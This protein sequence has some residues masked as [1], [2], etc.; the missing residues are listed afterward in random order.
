MEK[1]RI[2]RFLAHAGMGSRRK[3]EEFI[4]KGF[5]RVNGNVVKDLSKVVDPNVDVIEFK[6]KRVA[7]KRYYYLVLNK[8]KGYLTTVSDNYGR[9]H[10]MQL[11]PEQYKKAGVVPVGRLDKDTE[12]LLL[13]TNDGDVAYILTH[14]KFGVSKEYIVELDKPL[15]DRDKKK[16][17]GG[18]C[19]EKLRTNPAEIR[20]LDQ[21]NRRLI[22]K[23]TEGKKR[24]IR[25]TFGLFSY[26]IKKLKRI[27][28]GPLKLGNLHS[29]S[30]RVLKDREAQHLKKFTRALFCTPE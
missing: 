21:T 15:A 20:M 18:V 24:Q 27:G 11:I 14:P 7:I 23:I 13:F 28:F 10:V 26:K 19:I 9:K 16:I 5:V 17:E 30:Y 8:P 25:I 4:R 6:N 1:M 2:N 3:V 12:G 29:G 22:I